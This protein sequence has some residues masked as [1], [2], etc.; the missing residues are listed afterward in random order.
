MT[1]RGRSDTT[2]TMAL[3]RNAGLQF[4][5]RREYR[6]L[7]HAVQARPELAQQRDEFVMTP[8][9]WIC[10]DPDVPQRVLLQV[11]LAFPSATTLRNLAGLLPL[12]LAVRKELPLDALKVLLKFYPKAIVLDTPG[13]RS[14][15]DFA[16]EYV[17]SHSSKVF[18]RMME[19]Q[20]RE[21]GHDP[22]PQSSES[23]RNKSLPQRTASQRSHGGDSQPHESSVTSQTSSRELAPQDADEDQTSVTAMLP[24]WKLRKYCN[25]CDIKFGYFKNRH[26]CRNCGESVCGRHSNHAVSLKHLGLFRP[27]RVCSQC[28]ERLQ[29]HY[30]TRAMARMSPRSLTTLLNDATYEDNLPVEYAY[31]P[32]ARR[33]LRSRSAF[34]LPTSAALE[35]L[36]SPRDF[37]KAS[38]KTLDKLDLKTRSA[39]SAT[40][41]PRSSRTATSTSSNNSSTSLS[42]PTASK[43]GVQS[44]FQLM[45]S[46]FSM[47][48]TRIQRTDDQLT[49]QERQAEMQRRRDR[50]VKTDL[51]AYTS[52]RQ[53]AQR[54]SDVS[55][56]SVN[57]ED[58]AMQ[59]EIHMERLRLAK[60]QIQAA[61]MRSKREAQIAREQRERYA[62]I[63][64][65]YEDRG[66][67]CENEDAEP[68]GVSND[69]VDD[70]STQENANVREGF[71][72]NILAHEDRDSE[73]P[74]PNT[75]YATVPETTPRDE[76]DESPFESDSLDIPLDVAQTHHE[77]G[78]LFLSKEE[79]GR[80]VIELEKSAKLDASNALTL[81]HLAKALDGK[82]DVA[83]AENAIQKSLALE[84]NSVPSLSLLGKLLNGRGNH[85]EAIEVFRRALSLQCPQRR[86]EG[87][88]AE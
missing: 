85:D 28:Y 69:S 3:P 68:Q 39:R 15:L 30:T 45:P 79:Y 33:D 83:E 2:T 76:V 6:E 50:L 46:L 35:P 8:L 66:Y 9:H 87:P 24:Q 55:N 23:N 49:V 82:G 74:L 57:E 41:S 88:E 7:L 34:E 40:M 4:A 52:S 86:H 54:S 70:S 13:G 5:E 62:I 10:T 71:N 16:L 17:T 27:Q 44:N 63:A 81:Y 53:P 75:L 61:L 77:L 60:K 38:P 56:Q 84:P 72:Y 48:M 51:D 37:S 29:S 73:I 32:I 59:L 14:T 26:H 43:T 65:A 58:H 1:S 11:I 31:S 36:M 21:M 78:V 19:Q 20:V 64:Q 80:A 12:H 67:T 18:L 22:Q 25:V 47:H 42:G